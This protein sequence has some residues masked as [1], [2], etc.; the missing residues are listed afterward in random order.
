VVNYLIFLKKGGGKMLN[1]EI[2]EDFTDVLKKILMAIVVIFM[3]I[4]R[5]A[6]TLTNPSLPTGCIRC[7]PRVPT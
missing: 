7:C 4:T 1:Y 3:A 2:V 6:G 5:G